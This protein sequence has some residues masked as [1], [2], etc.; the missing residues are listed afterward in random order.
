MTNLEKIYMLFVLIGGP[1]SLQAE[2]SGKILNDKTKDG[3]EIVSVAFG[4]NNWWNPTAY[5]T[6]CK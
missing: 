6:L 1:A 4:V 2:S 3:Y 5:I